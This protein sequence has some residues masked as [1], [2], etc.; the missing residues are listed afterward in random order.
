[1]HTGG[2]L[3]HMGFQSIVETRCPHGDIVV[4]RIPKMKSRINIS[5]VNEVSKRQV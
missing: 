3:A 1:M 5:C 4:N 2:E